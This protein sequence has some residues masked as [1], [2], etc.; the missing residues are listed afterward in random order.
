MAEIQ[1]INKEKSTVSSIE[2]IITMSV[3]KDSVVKRHVKRDRRTIEEI[4][5]DLKRQKNTNGIQ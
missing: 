4:Q 2:Q 5:E 3:F 1:K